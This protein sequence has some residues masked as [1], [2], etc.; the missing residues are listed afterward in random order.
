METITMTVAFVVDLI[1]CAPELWLSGQR[2][3]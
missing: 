1:K 3:M 2:E